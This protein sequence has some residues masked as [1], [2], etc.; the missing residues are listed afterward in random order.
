MKSSPIVCTALLTVICASWVYAQ[1]RSPSGPAP[2][3]SSATTEGAYGLPRQPPMPQ[4]TSLPR[5]AEAYQSQ[6]IPGETAAE[7]PGVPHY[8]YPPYPNPFYEEFPQRKPLT[9]G[10]EWLRGLP[11]N[12]AERFSSFIDT[13]FFPNKA[14]T[15]GGAP[16]AQPPVSPPTQSLPQPFMPKAPRL[17]L[18]PGAR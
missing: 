13:T 14:A 9:D 3:V 6:T 15:H 17:N 10:M 2:S 8:P 1:Q 18:I 16:S 7:D 5:P 4:Q 12:V 11:S